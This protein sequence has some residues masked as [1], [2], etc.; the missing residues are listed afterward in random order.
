MKSGLQKATQYEFRV[1]GISEGRFG[2]WSEVVAKKAFF[3]FVWK[4]CPNIRL[5]DASHK[6]VE[7]IETGYTTTVGTNT[8][9]RNELINWWLKILTTN[10]G[11]N[12]TAVGVA[13]N[14]I[15]VTKGVMNRD[16]YGW[17]F[18]F[19]GALLFSG[20]PQKTN[21]MI[22]GKRNDI[23]PGDIITVTIDT[24]GAKGVLSFSINGISLGTAFNNI[25]LDK[26]LVP[27]VFFYGTNE[28]IELL[29]VN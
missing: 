11:K 20:P 17:Y 14:D 10:Q 13:P 16:N 24:R 29:D 25:P 28:K 26:P 18:S 22:Y 23:K 21:S 27:V 6:I 2:A 4:Q 9:P 7:S 3:D 8:I 1:R 5:C 15:A 12:G 19:F